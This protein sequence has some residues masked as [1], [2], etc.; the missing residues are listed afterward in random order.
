MIRI[1]NVSKRFGRT[2]AVDGVSLDLPAGDS[3]ALWGAN[4]AGKTTLIRCV[5]GLLRFQGRIAVGGRDVLR[6]GK[7]ARLLVGYV[8]QELGFHDE[9]GVAEAVRFFG[10]LKG[11]PRPDAEAALASV[12]LAGHGGKRVRE[13]SGGMKQ[14]LALAIALLGDPPVLVL[15]EVTAS[16][17]AVGREELVGLLRGLSGRGRT[18]LFASHRPEEVAVLARRVAVME[19]GRIIRTAPAC[20]FAAAHQGRAVLHLVM[21]AEHRDRAV[22]SLADG[23]FAA[24]LNGVGVLVHVAPEHKAA[25]FR[26]L[27]QAGIAV[28][29]FDLAPVPE[30]TP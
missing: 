23:G 25:P 27:A 1:E 8:P 13:L 3:V 30:R 11:L 12:G 15:D 14:R 22:R 4:G 17:D 26:L 28:D 18:L 6:D 20:D 24:S 19:R 9:L 16:L 29:D 7:R 21:A 10:R 2:R 5:L